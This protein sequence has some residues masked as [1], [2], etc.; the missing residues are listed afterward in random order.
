ML[1]TGCRNQ[2]NQKHLTGNV[3]RIENCALTKN[4]STL[5]MLFDKKQSIEPTIE[6]LLFLFTVNM[7]TV[8]K[9]LLWFYCELRIKDE[10]GSAVVSGSF[11]IR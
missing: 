7:C 6:L 5:W 9:F 4:Q 11:Y 2:N 3:V 10:A 8:V 1:S